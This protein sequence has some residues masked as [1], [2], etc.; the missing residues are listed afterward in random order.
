MFPLK[1]NIPTDR[2]PVVTV[3]LILANV[4]VYLFLQDAL[5]GLPQEGN[6]GDW[7]VG[8]YAFIP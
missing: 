6:G 8:T 4:M 5:L 7:P 2:F 1:D 3:A